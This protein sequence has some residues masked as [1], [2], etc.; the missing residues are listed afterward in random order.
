MATQLRLRRA[1]HDETWRGRVLPVQEDHNAQATLK[2]FGP[3]HGGVQMQMRLILPG[4]EVLETPQVLAVDLPVVLAAYPASLWGRPG[5]EKPAVSVAPPCSDR[6][7]IEA[8]QEQL[9]PVVTDGM[10][11][12]CGEGGSLTGRRAGSSVDASSAAKPRCP[13]L[14]PGPP[15]DGYA[16]ASRST[17]IKPSA[18]ACRFP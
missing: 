16:T 6:G 14:P 4:A 10:G 5:V 8:S 18:A 1:Q 7:Q 3:H 13:W 9:R 12:L 11:Y 17:T 15:H 2:R